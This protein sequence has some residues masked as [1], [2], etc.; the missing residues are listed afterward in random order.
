[1]KHQFVFIRRSQIQVQKMLKR[2]ERIVGDCE[3]ANESA[4]RWLKWLGAK[5]DQPKDGLIHFTIKRANG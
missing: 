2:Y 1:M 3:E 5:F 4:Q